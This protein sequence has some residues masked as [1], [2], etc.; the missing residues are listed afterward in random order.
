MENVKIRNP[1]NSHK[2]FVLRSSGKRLLLISMRRWENKSKVDPR[3][4][5]L[6]ISN[7]SVYRMSEI[8]RLNWMS[9][10]M[11][12]TTIFISLKGKHLFFVTTVLISVCLSGTHVHIF[13]YFSINLAWLLFIY[14]KHESFI[15]SIRGPIA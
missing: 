10:A 4:I 7:F 13:A 2:I 11:S 8:F 3:N 1:K 12:Q 9:C 5:L 14:R 6:W 15:F